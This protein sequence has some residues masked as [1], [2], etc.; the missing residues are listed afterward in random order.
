MPSL[1][2]SLFWY[3]TFFW[4]PARYPSH[5]IK[6]YRTL[7]DV[8]IVIIKVMTKLYFMR[9]CGWNLGPE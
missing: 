1:L 6:Q 8:I 3:A 7:L 5:V 2:W 9:R 4:K